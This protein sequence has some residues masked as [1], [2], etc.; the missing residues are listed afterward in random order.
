M[1]YLERLPDRAAAESLKFRLDWKIAFSLPLEFKGIHHTTLVYFRDRLLETEKASLAFDKVLEHLIKAG[2][3]RSKMRQRIDSTHIIGNVRELS[4]VELLHETLRLFCIEAVAYLG[5][6]DKK[7]KEYQELYSEK[8]SIKGITDAQKSRFI[9]EAGLAMRAFI[10]LGKQSF[11][12]EVRLLESYKTLVAVFEQNFEDSIDPEDAPKLIKVATG[13]GHISSPHETEA[14]F[15]NKGKKKWLGYKAQV[16]ETVSEETD[17]V[18][19]ITHIEANEA[20]DFDGDVVDRVLDELIEKGVAPSELYGDTHYNTSDNI[21]NLENN[22]IALKGPVMP[23]SLERENKNKGFE[24]IPEEKKVICPQGV[25]SKRY[26]DQRKELISASFPED[27]CEKCTRREVCSPEKHG[28]IYTT[29]PEDKILNKR[30][31]EMETEVFK[32][33]MHKRNGVEGTLSGLIRGQGMRRTRYRG[34][35]KTNMHMKFAGVAA[36]IL[37]LHRYRQIEQKQIE[38]EMFEEFEK[39]LKAS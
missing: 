26:N 8:I 7:L 15:S 27:A 19:F 25:T 28:K 22:D 36:N 9:R 21:K 16:V 24:I 2:L 4:R 18:N 30:R 20:T 37:R 17:D 10:E 31:Q 14:R 29:R 38:Q 1:Q 39:I 35:S 3:V 34:K 12:R 6:V 33:D 23:I 32:E 5:N 11:C 13:K